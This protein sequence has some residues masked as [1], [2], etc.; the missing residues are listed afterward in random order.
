MEKWESPVEKAIREAQERGEFDNLPGSGRPLHLGDPERDD[1][2]WWVKR[3]AERE[4]L[5]LSGAMS[6]A[7]GLRKE[8]ASYPESLLDLRSEASVRAVLEDYNR[9]VKLDRLRPGV[10]AS[11]PIWAPLVDV[12]D[13]V[14]RWWV[15]RE[16]ARAD[17]EREA[18]ARA[19][20]IAAASATDRHHR[21]L[22]RW[23]RGLK[24]AGRRRDA[25]SD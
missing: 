1:P 18:A 3:F 13:L 19:A 5:D 7:M 22:P 21:H 15:A 2:D 8:A 12:D 10:G 20:S 6:P 25:M 9:R 14:Q 17:R 11:Y 24:G 16:T 23:I 4:H